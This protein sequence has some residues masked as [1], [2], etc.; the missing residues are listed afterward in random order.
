MKNPFLII[1]ILFLIG[2]EILGAKLAYFTIGEIA[3]GLYF[4]LII[5][6]IV[7]L[8]YLALKKREALAYTI[9]L[10]IGL[11]I[12]PYQIYLDYKL[13]FLREEGG[14]IVGYLYGEK[15]ENGNYPENIAD[16]E[17]TYPKLKNNFNY[18]LIDGHFE[19]YYTV[20]SEHTPH[21][22]RSEYEKWGY[23]PD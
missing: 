15:L 3:S 1:S 22:F 18:Y 19:L 14:N 13:I 8:I 21:Y 16:Y 23:Y 6:N 9:L 10:V 11:T 20:G 5:L 12:I 2:L 17:F 4:I 7:P